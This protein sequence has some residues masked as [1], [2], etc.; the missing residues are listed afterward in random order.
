M[1]I[2]TT[3]LL[4]LI[5]NNF[6]NIIIFFFFL[7]YSAPKIQERDVSSVVTVVRAFRSLCDGMLDQSFMVDP[8]RDSPIQGY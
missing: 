5:N 4:K 1:T 6:K 7:I 3:C 2:K 8:F